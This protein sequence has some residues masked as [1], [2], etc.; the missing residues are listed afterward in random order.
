VSRET[1]WQTATAEFLNT[2]EGQHWP[3]GANNLTILGWLLRENGLQDAEDKV[4]A[5]RVVAHEMRERGLLDV[6]SPPKIDANASPAEILRSWK[7]AYS[8]DPVQV[9]EA[10]RKWFT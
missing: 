6:P 5:L 4:A 2:P 3:G 7:A 10:F 9:G 8:N 1:E